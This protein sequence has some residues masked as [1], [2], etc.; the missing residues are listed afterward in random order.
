MAIGRIQNPSCRHRLCRDPNVIGRDHRSLLSQHIKNLGVE[1]SCLFVGMVNRGSWRC[2]KILEQRQLLVRRLSAPRN[3]GKQFR[4]CCQ[5]DYQ[6][7]GVHYRPLHLSARALEEM[8][9]G[10]CIENC[11]WIHFHISSSIARI[12]FISRFQAFASIS[13]IAP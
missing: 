7:R 12:S 3:P 11:R 5:R 2:E 4:V 13:G 10:A 8:D 9:D 1:P 6:P